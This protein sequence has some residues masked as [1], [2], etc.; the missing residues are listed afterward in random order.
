[1]T[2]HPQFPSRSP[3]QGSLQLSDDDLGILL[4]SLPRE[5]AALGF[6]SRVLRRVR[7]NQRP[8][9]LVRGLRVS[10]PLLAAA[11]L[12]FMVGPGIFDR[13][14]APSDSAVQEARSESGRVAATGMVA[15]ARPPA[16]D[17]GG[18]DVGAGSGLRE[19]PSQH[20]LPRVGAQR[21]AVG[22]FSPARG[23]PVTTVAVGSSLAGGVPDQRLAEIRLQ[24]ER[25][26]RQ[27]EELR[28]VRADAGSM[29]TIA[30]Q[31]GVEIQVD[32]RELL[33]ELERQALLGSQGEA[34]PPVSRN[35]GVEPPLGPPRW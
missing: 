35:R 13:T 9:L 3:S 2:K 18:G 30:V 28:R 31:D 16:S 11:A 15:A 6:E 1:M 19:V 4:R 17:V 29:V 14:S 34:G 7:E 22:G 23:G 25:V 20:V 24:A 26:R 10:L 12:G 33:A 21:T 27:L 5:E 32:L 8:A